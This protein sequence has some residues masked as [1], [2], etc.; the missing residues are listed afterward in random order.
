MRCGGGWGCKVVR[1][2]QAPALQSSLVLAC[3]Q[4]WGLIGMRVVGQWYFRGCSHRQMPDLNQWSG[5]LKATLPLAKGAMRQVRPA[6]RQASFAEFVHRLKIEEKKRLPMFDCWFDMWHTHVDWEGDGNTSR[7]YR[8][9]QLRALFRLFRRIQATAQ[10]KQLN[11]Q[12]F[13][14]V[15]ACEPGQDAVFIHTTNPNGTPYPY[16]PSNVY[17]LESLPSWLAPHVVLERY[18]VGVQIWKAKKSYFIQRRRP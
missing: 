7:M 3:R 18:Q 8:H 13:A 2:V 17:W 5:T 16:L 1:L 15:T 4:D 6:K 14:V 11:A 9:A 12:V 10:S